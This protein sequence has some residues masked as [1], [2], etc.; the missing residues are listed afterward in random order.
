MSSQRF[1]LAASKCSRISFRA[2]IFRLQNFDGESVLFRLLQKS[3][4]ACSETKAISE[5]QIAES[6]P[7]VLTLIVADCRGMVLKIGLAG[8]FHRSGIHT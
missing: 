1:I 6:A 5:I 3:H 8:E 7:L 2:F 4:D